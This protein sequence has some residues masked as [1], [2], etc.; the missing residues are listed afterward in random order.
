MTENLI[1]TKTPV[2]YIGMLL[3]F[4]E[5]DSI[6]FFYNKKGEIITRTADS[7]ERRYEKL[8]QP[9]EF[10]GNSI[11]MGDISERNKRDY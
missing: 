4:K 3:G 7:M 6:Y 9:F 11:K 10:F 1:P 8:I 5:R 2:G